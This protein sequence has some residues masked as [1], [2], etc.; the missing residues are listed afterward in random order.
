MPRKP[1]LAARQRILAAAQRLFHEHGYRGVSMEDVAAAAGLKKANLFHYYPSKDELG[2][3]V[4]DHA[5]AG[6]RG[7]IRELF[8]DSGSPLAAIERLFDQGRAWMEGSHCRGG[9][10]IGNLAQEVSDHHEGLRVKIA[11]FLDFWIGEI[12]AQL[13]RGRKQG[14]FRPQLDPRVAAEAIH[15]LFEG[16]LTA[17]K[18]RKDTTP[19]DSARHL[20]LAYL[21]GYR[22]PR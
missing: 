19:L 10:L 6:M 15:A 1:N 4:L 16:A 22:A 12:A 11:E 3:A 8:P 14:F 18:A 7:Q 20:A 2:L 21:R 13:A 9:C 5:A 17:C